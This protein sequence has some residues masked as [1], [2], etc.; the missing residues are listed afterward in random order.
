MH[1]YQNIEIMILHSYSDNNLKKLK[2]SPV[3]TFE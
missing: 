2:P 1:E 3:L